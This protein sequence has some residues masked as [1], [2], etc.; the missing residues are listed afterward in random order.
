MLLKNQ[1]HYYQVLVYFGFAY[2]THLSH[3]KLPKLMKLNDLRIRR[4]STLSMSLIKLLVEQHR[5]RISFITSRFKILSSEGLSGISPLSKNKTFWINLKN[6]ASYSENPFPGFASIL[7]L[8]K[9]LA[10][11]ETLYNYKC[12]YNA[13]VLKSLYAFCFCFVTMICNAAYFNYRGYYNYVI[14]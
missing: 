14:I 10:N 5:L 12:H 7:T 6:F 11:P 1:V 8:D 4:E 2:A 9:M 3:W 13:D